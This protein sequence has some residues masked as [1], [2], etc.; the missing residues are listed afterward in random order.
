MTEHPQRTGL[1]KSLFGGNRP[2]TG[3]DRMKGAGF[4][5]WLVISCAISWAILV[6]LVEEFT[7]MD[8]A[9]WIWLL[10]AIPFG[11]Y[12]AWMTARDRRRQ[13]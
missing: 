7:D 5:L 10:P 6:S 12:V 2:T 11:A 3:T 9:R 4:W 13:G 8:W 1:S